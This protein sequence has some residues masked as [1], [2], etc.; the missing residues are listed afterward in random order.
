M[1]TRPR[2]P[3]DVELSAVL[4]MLG[5]EVHSSITIDMLDDMR[6]E[7]M[8]LPVDELIGGRPIAH[9][10]HLVPGP[11]GSPDLLVTIFHRIDHHVSGPA[12]YHTH[13]GGMIMGDRFYGIEVVL[14][15]V[16]TLDAVA[17][18]VEYRLAPEHPDPAPIEDCYAGLL[19][20]M[21]NADLLR[22]DPRKL[23]VVGASAGG[24]LVAGLSLMV[25][26]QGGPSLAGQV[27]IY[28]MLDDRNTTVSSCQLVGEGVWDRISN[29]TA[30]DALL[31]MRRKTDAV[32]IYAAPSRATD[33]SRLP[34]TYIE[35]GSVDVFRDEDVAFASEI[36]AAG[37]SAELHVWPG[38]FH[39]F[40][41]AAPL[42]ALSVQAKETRTRWVKRTLGL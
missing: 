23:I 26:D 37:G 27:L 31:G 19:W 12:F 14:D 22:F 34:P 41:L 8:S 30:W 38:A 17:V 40:D 36:W 9:E 20:M 3:F 1:T 5:D 39:G 21:D 7:Q 32:S 42:A 29:D 24:G 11:E 16:H 35:V 10:E 15:W 4:A 13:G 2:P 33:L 28:P 6:I 25:R 18:T